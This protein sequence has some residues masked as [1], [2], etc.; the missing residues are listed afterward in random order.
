MSESE[1][2]RRERSGLRTSSLPTAERHEVGDRSGG[3]LSRRTFVGL[4]AGTLLLALTPGL[5]WRR[6]RR[7][8]RRT[9]PVMG[10]LAE[11]IVVEDDPDRARAAIEAAFGELRAVD[12]T[13]SRFDARSDVGRVNGGP[14]GRRIPVAGATAGVVQAG[15]R[16]AEISGGRFDPG[17]ARA[18]AL[19]DVGQRE[20]PPPDDAFRRYAGRDLYRELTVEGGAGPEPAIVRFHPDVGVDL[21]GVAKGHAVD[22]AVGALRSHGIRHGMVN[23]GGD[24]F[25]LGVSPEGDPWRVGVRDPADPT[26][27]A[28]EIELT[29]RAVATSGDYEQ[30]FEHGGLRYHHLLDPETGAPR[31]SAVRSVTVAADDGLTADAAATACF[32]MEEGEIRRLLAR[33]AS[34]AEL[35]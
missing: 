29:D 7:V 3:G 4:G 25:A 2:K 18:V 13:M 24:L 8:H 15:L 22:R 21:G 30:Y 23:A 5:L 9:L 1:E 19:W 35:V 11:V 6:R 26:R 14:V 34:G 28:G 20:V 31:R 32:G 27:L 33:A 17:L 12:R 10:T 16:W